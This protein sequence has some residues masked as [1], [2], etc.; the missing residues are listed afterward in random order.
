MPNESKRKVGKKE[1]KDGIEND[2]DNHEP[3]KP[4]MGVSIVIIDDEGSSI[5]NRTC[6]ASCML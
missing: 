4:L 2:D 3:L 1:E 5:S 6:L